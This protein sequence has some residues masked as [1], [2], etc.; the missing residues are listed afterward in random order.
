MRHPFHSWE[1]ECAHFPFS[2][3]LPSI[4]TWYPSLSGTE[5]K[6]PG[7]VSHAMGWSYSSD[8]YNSVG[9]Q[10]RSWAAGDAGGWHWLQEGCWRMQMAQLR[11]LW[12]FCLHW[13]T[14]S[15]HYWEEKK[16]MEMKNSLRYPNHL[17]KVSSFT[18][19]LKIQFAKPNS[20]SK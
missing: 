6:M 4:P 19:I 1:S 13:I 9:E 20:N 3:L 16:K 11:I 14:A 15:D 7:H 17:T 10:L 2:S 5:R 18:K 12:A 8:D